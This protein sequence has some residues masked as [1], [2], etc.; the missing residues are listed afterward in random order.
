MEEYHVHVEKSRKE[1]KPLMSSTGVAMFKVYLWFALGLLITGVVSLTIPN[2]LVSLVETSE[3]SNV[4]MVGYST[5]MILSIVL[6]LRNMMKS[7]N[8]RFV[9]YMILSLAIWKIKRNGSRH[10]VTR[11]FIVFCSPVESNVSWREKLSDKER[12]GLL[13]I[14]FAISINE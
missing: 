10:Q 7:I 14:K 2:L 3:D 1:T 9:R 8:W 6:M 11:P 4:I 13:A 12:I 5:A